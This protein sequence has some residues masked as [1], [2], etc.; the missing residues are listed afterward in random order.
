MLK[1]IE[2]FFHEALKDN[3]QYFGHDAIQF[4]V[5]YAYKLPENFVLKLIKQAKQEGY[6]FK[7]SYRDD[8]YESWGQAAKTNLMLLA[9]LNDS[10]IRDVPHTKLVKFLLEEGVDPFYESITIPSEE[11]N[12]EGIGLDERERMLR[13]STR[14]QPFNT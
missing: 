14:N 10:Q 4:F 1:E 9:V 5:R 11:L 12:E 3:E 6:N 13:S 7:E 8:G 2:F